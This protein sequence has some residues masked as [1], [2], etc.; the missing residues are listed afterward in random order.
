M[1]NIKL[2][3]ILIGGGNLLK[4]KTIEDAY[5][6]L[7]A[8]D[9]ELYSVYDSNCRKVKLYKK[10]EYNDVGFIIEDKTSLCEQLKHEIQ[11]Y[12]KEYDL[13]QFISDD[14]DSLLMSIPYYKIVYI[15]IWMRIQKLWNTIF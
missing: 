9:I 4:Y 12:G 15:P 13:T 3:I 5:S 11:K 2:P 8:Y 14:L 10:S 6:D 1:I 7:E